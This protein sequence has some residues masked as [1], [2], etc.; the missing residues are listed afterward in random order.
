[1][2]WGKCEVAGGILYWITGLSGAGK[3][4]IGSR[5]AEKLRRDRESVVLLDGDIL[6]NIVSDKIGYSY[7]ERK[8]RALKYAMMCKMLVDQGMLVICCTISMYD[9][10]REWNRKNN[11]KYVEVFLNVPLEVLQARD[12]KGIYSK[13]KKGEITNLSGVDVRAE[14]PENPDIE[15]KNDGHLTIEECVDFIMEYH[16]HM[17][18]D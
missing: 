5:L 17:W 14:F 2:K 13:Y 1:M 10:V 12:Q 7:E 3:T 18:G 16:R 15:L 8:Q 11:E 9:E 4:T 6:K